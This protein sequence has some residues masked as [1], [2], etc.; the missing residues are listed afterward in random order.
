[1]SVD[2]SSG[3]GGGGEEEKKIEVRFVT[4]LGREYAVADT[5]FSVPARLT[6]RGLSEVVNHLLRLGGEGRSDGGGGVP[7]DFLCAGEFVRGS[8]AR[9]LRE[10]GRAGDEGTVELEYTLAQPQPNDLPSHQHGDWVAALCVGLC[11]PGDDD[12]DEEEEEFVASGGYD[13]RIRLWAD[14]GIA[15]SVVDA[16]QT[17]V[18]AIAAIGGSGSGMMRRSAFVSAGKDAVARVWQIAPTTADEKK[19]TTKTMTTSAGEEEQQHDGQAQPLTVIKVAEL[20]GHR[21]GIDG[22]DVSPDSSHACTASWDRTVRVWDLTAH[23]HRAKESQQQREEE[24]EDEEEDGP[25]AKKQKGDRDEPMEREEGEEEEEEEESESKEEGG[26]KAVL[27][28]HTDAVTCVQWPTHVQ[29]VSGGHDC[30]IRL[31]DAIRS[32]NVATLRGG[33]AVGCIGYS[34]ENGVCASGHHDGLVRLWDPRASGSGAGDDGS[35]GSTAVVARTLRAHKGWVCGVAWH[36]TRS[37]LMLSGSHDGSI[38]VWDLRSTTPLHTARGAHGGKVLSV[39]WWLRER[40][41]AGSPAAT[42]TVEIVS[43]GADG[44]VARRALP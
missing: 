13:R 16:H 39:A 41:A 7:F 29:L 6:R 30:A 22:V 44:K 24:E 18:K 35:S 34:T 8:L 17:A 3:S 2:G 43:G 36:P 33:K 25:K 15:G 42:T 5:A 31:W 12:G 32:K 26:A 14:C 21:G 28:G 9:H 1:M 23:I 4:R 20:V 10:R 27:E 37:T 38:K 11:R 19:K 40:R